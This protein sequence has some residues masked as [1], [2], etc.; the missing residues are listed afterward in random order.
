M[1]WLMLS[2]VPVKNDKDKLTQ[3]IFIATDISRIKHLQQQN[4]KLTLVDYLTELPNR[5]F[6]WNSLENY[7]TQGMPCYVLY[8][9]I[10]NFKVIN[11][12]LGH[13]Y[14]DDILALVAEQ[15][16]KSVKKRRCCSKNWR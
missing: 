2:I 7:I 3:W 16:K 9:D 4:E 10:E 5:Q 11:D 12:E 8:I 1:K 15:L 13:S 14:G 6:F